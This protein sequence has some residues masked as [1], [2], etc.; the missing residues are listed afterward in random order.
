MA[1]EAVL[2][3]ADD[4]VLLIT[5]NRPASATR[6]TP[7]SPTGSR[8]RWTGSTTRR[9]RVGV[10]TGAGGLLLR[11]GPQG[12]R[13]RRA[14]VVEG[15]GFAGIAQRPP[16]KP[17]IA[18]VEG[19]ALAGGFE[20]ALACDLIVAA[21][22]ARFGIPEVKRA[23]VA[24]GG[25]LMRLPSASPTTWRWSWRSPATRSAPS[26]RPSSGSSTA[27]PSRAMRSTPRASSPPRSPQRPARARR[28]QVDRPR[29]PDWTE[30]EAWEQQA[31]ITGPVF[32]SEDA[33]EG[34][35]AF[36]EKRDPVWKGR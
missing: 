13:G 22:G 12:V 3:E 31:E 35:T 21:R 11:D 8:P 2:T 19:F 28:L 7:R 20:V 27:S 5:L 1:D 30:E 29:A 6:S 33:R 36:A 18:A 26:A 14:A 34:A 23:L 4:G 25:A 32:G 10:L 17:L 15:R 24:A 9:L 16:R